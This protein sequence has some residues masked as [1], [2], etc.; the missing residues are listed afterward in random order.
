[1]ALLRLLLE[2]LAD[3]V[4]VDLTKDNPLL[5]RMSEKCSD[6]LMRYAVN[7]V[8]FFKAPSVLVSMGMR[9]IDVNE[10]HPEQL[11]GRKVT[12]QPTYAVSTLLIRL[13]L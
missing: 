6:K 4:D 2:A 10:I 7:L 5:S 3:K 12:T 9:D 11:T 13:R 1:M 8:T